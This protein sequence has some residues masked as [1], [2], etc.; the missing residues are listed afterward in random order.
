MKSGNQFLLLT[1][2]KEPLGFAS[3]GVEKNSDDFKLH[4][5]YVITDVHHKGYGKALLQ[6]VIAEVKKRSGK[7]LILQV[8]RNNEKAIAFY[9]RNGFLIE[10]SADFDIG[11]GFQMNDYVMGINI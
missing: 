1:V 3:Y 11:N 5:L 2:D 4:K 6:R 7:H 8:N 9:L 10:Q